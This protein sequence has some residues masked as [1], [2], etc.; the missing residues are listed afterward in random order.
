MKAPYNRLRGEFHYVGTC[1]AG[2]C[3]LLTRAV[4]WTADS[5]WLSMCAKHARLTLKNVK[6][7]RVDG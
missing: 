2:D 5:G 3:G 7:V 4:V 6:D 1:D